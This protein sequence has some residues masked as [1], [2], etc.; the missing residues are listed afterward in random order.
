MTAGRKTTNSLSRVANRTKWRSN[1]GRR[2]LLAHI[3]AAAEGDQACAPATSGAK[4]GRASPRTANAADCR[5]S[6]STEE[7]AP[8]HHEIDA[9][10]QKMRSRSWREE[11][12][13]RTFRSR[14]GTA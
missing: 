2:K 1:Y 4:D 14:A 11:L 9:S 6:P 5:C 3:S 13:M 7:P 8:R 10:L 12:A